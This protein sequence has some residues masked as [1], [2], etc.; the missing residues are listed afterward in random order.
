MRAVLLDVDGV[1][2]VSGRAVPDAPEAVLALR[3][4]GH[5]VRFV[6]N[7]TVRARA[8]LASDLRALGFELA[9]EELETVPVAAAHFLAGSRVLPLTMR[10][11]HAD[12][13]ESVELVEEDADVVLVGG[14]DE[15]DENL[16]AFGWDRLEAAFTELERGA[17]LVALHRNR[18][19]Q[20][21]S[22]PR[23]D[24]ALV[25]AGLEEVSGVRAELVGKPSP[26]L[27]QGALESI[28]GATNGATMVGDDVEADIGAA[29]RI[30]VEA[31][32]VRTGKFR[33]DTLAAADP[34]PDAVLDSVADVPDFVAGR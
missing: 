15:T 32:L 25:V 7:N 14:A 30:G 5:P 27:L 22:G 29:K 26:A 34:Q 23:M 6:T 28:G 1:L 2:Q 16:E 19:W 11:I 21:A 8:V 4:A 24:S 10:A 13:A 17:R 18:W 31:V 20:T 33:P 12:L 9:E 3:E